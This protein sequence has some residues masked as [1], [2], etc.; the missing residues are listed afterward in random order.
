MSLE[1]DSIEGLCPVQGEGAFDGVPFYFRA[2]G[3]RIGIGVHA[4]D[5]LGAYMDGGFGWRMVEPWKP[6]ERFAAGYVSEG[7]ARA[8]IRRAYDAWLAASR[9]PETDER[10]EGA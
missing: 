6:G 4:T 3:E 8:F 2:R 9:S 5:P 1:I 10:T 7:D